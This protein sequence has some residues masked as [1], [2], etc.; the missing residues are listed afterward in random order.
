MEQKTQKRKQ[1]RAPAP[2]ELKF[3]EI[4]KYK[5]VSISMYYS[6]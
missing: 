3:E 5:E 1:T 2:Y 6:V 4:N